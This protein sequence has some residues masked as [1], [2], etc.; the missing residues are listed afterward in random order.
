MIERQACPTVKLR[1]D[2]LVG[3][4]E[5]VNRRLLSARDQLQ[6]N[7]HISHGFGDTRSGSGPSGI[8]V[9]HR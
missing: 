9:Q 2:G 5:Y 1:G 8:E 3:S 7:T 6:G 4:Y